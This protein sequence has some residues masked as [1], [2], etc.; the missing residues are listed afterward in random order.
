M[1]DD[2]MRCAIRC[3]VILL[4]ACLVG[5][6]ATPFLPGAFRLDPSES[7]EVVAGRY[8]ALPGAVAQAQDLPVSAPRRISDDRSAVAVAYAATTHFG[9]PRHGTFRP[10]LTRSADRTHASRSVDDD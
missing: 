9:P 2:D 5:D 6:M 1:W 7:V 8:L 3:A 10:G 4:A